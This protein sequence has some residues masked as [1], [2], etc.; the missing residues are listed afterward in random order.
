MLQDHL[1]QGTF[2]DSDGL[3]RQLAAEDFMVVAPYT[4]RYA[5]YAQ[6]LQAASV[7]ERSTSS[8]PAGADCLFSMATSTGEEI[9]RNLAILFPQSPQ[10]GDLSRVLVGLSRLFATPS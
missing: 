9:P 6:D 10:C 3:T 8:R 2:T 1:R 7:S 5:G 4:A